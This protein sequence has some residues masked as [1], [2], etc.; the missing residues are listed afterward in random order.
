MK[1]RRGM[2]ALVLGSAILLV[3]LPSVGMNW[4]SPRMPDPESM[5]STVYWTLRVPRILTGALAG[6]ILAAAGA[7]FQAVFRNPLS[8]PYTLGIASGASFGAALSL[9]FS[10]VLLIPESLSTVS[11]AVAGGL[12]ATAIVLG[13]SR[14][15]KSPSPATI[16]LAGIAV[17][18]LFSSLLMFLQYV[19]NLRSSF[20]IV[21]WLMG[22]LEVGGYGPAVILA[23][24]ALLGLPYLWIRAGVLNQLVTG[25]ELA[26][27]RGVDVRREQ[28]ILYLLTS[29][30]VCLV[31]AYCGPIGFIGM[32]VPHTCRILVGPDHRLLLPASAIAG[33]AF[34]CICDTLA[35]LVIAPA[36]IPVGVLTAL[37]GGP[38]FLALLYLK[39]HRDG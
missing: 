19:S 6:A 38:F 13:L 14:L 18:Y 33:A 5:D 27:A 36:E 31:V 39:F 10:A 30:L 32:M 35:R 16:L 20:H 29:V 3:L 9:V 1:T 17:S 23:L 12:A 34:L 4:I 22:G 8:T 26:L 21:R 11:G 25:H 24:A 2:T 37:L 28:T 15:L 7:V